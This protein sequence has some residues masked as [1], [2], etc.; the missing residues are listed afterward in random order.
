MNINPV[1]QPFRLGVDLIRYASHNFD[2]H[3]VTAVMRVVQSGWLAAGR[4]AHEFERAFARFLCVEHALLVNSGSSA[5]LLAIATLTAS[6]LKDRR[7]RPGDEVITTAA[8]FPTTVAPIVQNRAVPVFVDV[9]IGSYVPTLDAIERAVSNRTKAI[10]LAHTMGVPFPLHAVRELCDRCDLWLIEDNCDALG[11]TCG[12][13]LTG[14]VGDLSTCSFYPAHHIT[15]GEGGALATNNSELAKIAASFRDW[16]RDCWCAPARNNTC[17]KRFSQQHATLPF[18][19]DHKYVYTHIG[20]N[21]KATDL[22]AAVGVEQLKKLPAFVAAR[23]A[24]HA[25]LLAGLAKH[26]KHLIL[27]FAPE[28]TNPSWFGFVVSTSSRP[29][30]VALV[31]ALTRAKIETRQLFAGNLL[32]QPAYAEIEHRVVGALTVTDFIMNHTFFVG[33]HPLLTQGMIDYMIATF[34]RFFQP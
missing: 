24:N 34:D 23:R 12:G 5:N 28:H 2:E 18:G 33:V 3:E 19:Y 13:T 14:R 22:Q 1:P 31:E 6:E 25:R 4:E 17:G 21:L 30:L 20:Y 32:R 7:L 26:A 29:M 11:A 8:A 15:M 9:Q 10:M 27:P 16:G